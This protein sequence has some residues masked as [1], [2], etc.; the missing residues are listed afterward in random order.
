MYELR[1]S[2][3]RVFHRLKQNEADKVAISAMVE[4][5]LI[6]KRSFIEP[7]NHLFFHLL[8]VSFYLT[9]CKHVDVRV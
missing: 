6:A 1:Y 2:V 4:S 5:A 7:E 8:D 9:Y 3:T